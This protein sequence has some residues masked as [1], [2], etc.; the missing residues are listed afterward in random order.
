MSYRR[1]RA[2]TYRGNCQRHYPSSD[3]QISQIWAKIFVK[4]ID[5]LCPCTKLR[6]TNVVLLGMHRQVFQALGGRS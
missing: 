5:F 6:H 3:N 4:K 1:D 2:N